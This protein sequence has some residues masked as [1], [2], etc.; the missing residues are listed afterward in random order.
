MTTRGHMFVYLIV[1]YKNSKVYTFI[2]STGDFESRLR[3]HNASESVWVPAMVLRVPQDRDFGV[4]TLRD[5]WKRNARG[6]DSR[7]N[8]GF[9]LAKQFHMT[10][11]V[12]SVDTPVLNFLNDLKGEPKPVP[13]SFW[14]QF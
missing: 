12:H 1:R 3:Q 4:K 14:A 5:T 13:P 9:K 10:V 6:L 2:G 11:Y 7:V 8:Y